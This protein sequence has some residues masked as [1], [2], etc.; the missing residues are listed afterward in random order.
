[1]PTWRHDIYREADLIE[2][3]ARCWGYDKIPVGK[4]LHIEVSPQDRTERTAVRIRQF[5]TG[6]GFYETVTVS[7]VNEAAASVFDSGSEGRLL[8]RDENQK[9]TR[10]LRQSLLGSLITV[11]QSNANAGNTDCRFFELADTFIGRAGQMPVERMKLSFGCQGDFRW[12]RGVIEGLCDMICPGAKLV[13]RPADFAWASSAAQVVLDGEII[14]IAGVLSADLAERFDLSRLGRISL[15]EVD[16]LALM[17]KTGAAVT[18]KPIPRFPAVCRDLSLIV[19]EPLRWNQIVEAI[20]SCDIA[21][22]EN[23]KFMGL[24]RGKPIDEGKKSIT[25]SLAFRDE[26]GT[27]RHETV[28]EFEKKILT[29][30][31]ERLKAELRTV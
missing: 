13:L 12:L 5:L 19:D 26:D 2:E 20:E 10:L 23:V 3:V 30:I 21:Q 28:D 29:V 18:A 22:L 4:K 11:M 7:F 31:K 27:L 24:Y 15:A 8:V 6:C 25:V 9:S 17:E 14:G 16:F 1:V